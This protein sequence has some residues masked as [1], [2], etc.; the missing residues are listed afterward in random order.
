MKQYKVVYNEAVSGG[1]YLSNK[2]L[3][4]L[5]EKGLSV[6]DDELKR[7]GAFV[8]FPRNNKVLVECVETLGEAANG[9]EDGWISKA[10]LQVAT[11]SGKY[12]YID[13]HDGAG[14]EVIDI[15]KMIDASK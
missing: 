7:Y 6:K 4:Y 3:D 15:S 13:D 1:I 10:E 11:I 12:Y 5:R 2:A 9:P 8:D 14:E